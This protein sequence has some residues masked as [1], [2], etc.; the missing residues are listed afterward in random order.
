MSIGKGVSRYSL[1]TLLA[2]T[3]LG[4]QERAFHAEP[5]GFAL[6]RSGAGLW[7]TQTTSVTMLGYGVLGEA[8]LGR[9][10]VVTE[11]IGIQ[12]LGLSTIPQPFSPEHGFSWRLDVT[13][14]LDEFASDYTSMVL[15]Y[16]AAGAT[17]FAGKFSR[18]WGPGMHSLFLS[19]KSPTFPQFGFDWPVTDQIHFTYSHGEL[20]S[21]ILDTLRAQASLSGPQRLY[22]DR[23][24]A[25]HRLE[26]RP[27]EKL[28]LAFSEAVVYGGKN[29]ETMYLMPFIL[30]FSAEHFLGDTDNL[31]MQVDAAW[32]PRPGLTLYGAWFLDDWEVLTTFDPKENNNNFAWQGGLDWRNLLLAGDRLAVEATWTDARIY[33]HRYPA[34]HHANRGYPLG[35]WAG[36]HAQALQA[37][38]SLRWRGYRFQG[39]YTYAKR[40]QLTLDM[41]RDQYEAELPPPTR[42]EEETESYQHLDFHIYRTLWRRLW[43]EVGLSLASWRN[44]GFDPAAPELPGEEITKSSVNLGLYYNFTLPGYPLTTLLRP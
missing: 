20:F 12:F 27:S 4:A 17:F 18:Q 38:Y 5:I 35:H 36:A 26:W 8:R 9:L 39:A 10:Q 21:G 32:R 28:T 15:T 19:E 25:A 7:D 13:D 14:S 44:A 2:V 23:F 33:R 30:F 11:V 43:L 16:E 3:L 29:L 1:T 37:L 24:V 31:Q 6:Y 40:G 22:V 34:N 41:L 42:F